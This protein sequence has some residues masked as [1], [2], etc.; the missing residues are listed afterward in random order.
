MGYKK[1]LPSIMPSFFCSLSCVT[2]SAVLD[3]VE[4][5]GCL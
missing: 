1:Y 5:I 2:I 3:V 4:I